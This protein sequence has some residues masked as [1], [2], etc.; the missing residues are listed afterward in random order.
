VA[1][2]LWRQWTAYLCI[3][4]INIAAVVSE[5]KSRTRFTCNLPTRDNV[6][7]ILFGGKIDDDDVSYNH[8]KKYL[9][10]TA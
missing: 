6:S 8:G 9:R 1:M 5:K 2:I 4:F 10:H 7:S 3:L